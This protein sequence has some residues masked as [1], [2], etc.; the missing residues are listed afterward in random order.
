MA[1]AWRMYIVLV[2]G[3]P[4]QKLQGVD[5]KVI[6]KAI[7]LTNK[8]EIVRYHVKLPRGDALVRVK[9]G[10]ILIKAGDIKSVRTIYNDR[11]IFKAK[12]FVAKPYINL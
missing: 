4:A 3:V 1:I 5:I 6:V 10:A 7:S 11:V 8:V 9:R 12:I 2:K